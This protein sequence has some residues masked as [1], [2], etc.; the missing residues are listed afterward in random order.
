MLRILL[1]D[2]DAKEHRILKMA[3]PQFLITSALYGREG[4][5]LLASSDQDI[6]L[7]DVRL[8]DMDGVALLE[9]ILD[10][11]DPPPVVMLSAVSDTRSVVLAMQK[12][13]A[14]YITKP[15]ELKALSKAIG[16]AFIMKKRAEVLDAATEAACS[17]LVGDD[18]RMKQ[19]K[20]LIQVYAQAE[21]PVLIT[22]ECGTGKEIA[23]RLIHELSPRRNG[24]FIAQNTAAIPITL[25]ETELF[26]SERGAYTG[27]V[28]RPGFFEQ[29]TGGTIF[30]DEI[31]ELELNAQVKLLR[32][33][34]GK[35]ICRIGGVK[36]TPIR[37]RII[38][39]TNKNLE[40]ALGNGSFRRDLFDRIS[41]L[42]IHMPPLRQRKGDILTLCN[43]FLRQS[44]SHSLIS[45]AAAEK[46]LAYS[47]PGNVRELKNVIQRAQILCPGKTIRREHIFFS[48][49]S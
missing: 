38:T 48:A 47:W 35:E 9:R 18:K 14:D 46:L 7:L 20:R 3:F 24:P 45:H 30:L 15:Y 23:A 27:A 42:P 11:A 33:I 19:V 43:H 22:G 5:N 41:T 17:A 21:V 36:R 31:G 34:E 10:S 6:I 26:G 40:L 13:A 12:G 32:A 28:T 37:A 16:E 49:P 8:P 1:I 39:A 44:G 25:M 2:D 4:L 29:A